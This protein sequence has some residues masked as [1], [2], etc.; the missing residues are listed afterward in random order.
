MI[1][2]LASHHNFQTFQLMKHFHDKDI[3][4]R[5]NVYLK[6]GESQPLPYGTGAE[7]YATEEVYAVLSSCPY[8]DA[9]TRV[10][11]TQTPV[12]IY[13]EVYDTGIEPIASPEWYD[14]QEVFRNKI[15]S[16]EKKSSPRTLVP[17][18]K[19]SN[20][21]ID[22]VN[23][24]RESWK[25]VYES[26][27]NPHTG[28]AY[29][30]KAGQV[31]QMEHL[32]DR[33]QVVDWM[34]ITPDLKIQ[35]SMGNTVPFDGYWI[36]KYTRI[37]GQQNDGIGMSPMMTMNRDDAA[38]Y[39]N[40]GGPTEEWASHQW[41]Y[42]CSPEWQECL[43]PGAP[44]Q[45]NSCHMN[46]VQAFLRVPAIAA[47][48]DETERREL[49]NQFAAGHN[50]QSFNPLHI[51]WNEESRNMKI[52]LGPCGPIK[53]GEGVEFYAEMDVYMVGSSCP[54]GNFIDPPYGPGARMPDPARIRVY[55]TGIAPLDHAGGWNDWHTAFYDMV[56]NGQKDISPRTPE[57]YEQKP[58]SGPN[59]TEL[60][61]KDE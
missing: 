54:Y 34:V 2:M 23:A 31:L 13:V 10:E 47:I 53:K 35:S 59:G 18:K 48:E 4:G 44:P 58:D 22:K 50:F 1:N 55:D 21:H 8:A 46:F 14:Y 36:N 6:L 45:I 17:K 12:P 7:F 43:F 24:A 40:W 52:Q 16:G 27:L 41:L 3:S 30:V 20:A 37:H 56:K 39:P 19:E 42:H 15:A 33:V 25:L 61:W 5:T 26:T 29:L 60:W 28:D 51:A 32:F 38:K 9:R 57:S 49:A 11:E